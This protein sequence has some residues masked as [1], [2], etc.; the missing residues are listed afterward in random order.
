[1][2]LSPSYFFERA[3]RLQR[4]YLFEVLLSAGVER[5][6]DALNRIGGVKLCALRVALGD[7]V[8]VLKDRFGQLVDRIFG[9]IVG[10]DQGRFDRDSL[11][12]SINAAVGAAGNAVLGVERIGLDQLGSMLVV[13]LKQV[14]RLG[15]CQLNDCS[16]R[17]TRGAEERVDLAVFDRIRRITETKVVV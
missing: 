5:Y 11:D 9:S 13:N 12:I 17:S 14:D 8:F 3:E 6:G 7:R 4:A 2:P 10:N 15:G 1:M 16:G